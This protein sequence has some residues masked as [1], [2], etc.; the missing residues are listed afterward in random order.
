[1]TI[2][3]NKKRTL[4]S[5]KRAVI[6]YLFGEARAFMIT[7]TNFPARVTLPFYR[8]HLQHSNV[9]HF[10]DE[11]SMNGLKYVSFALHFITLTFL[12]QHATIRNYAAIRL[13]YATADVIYNLNICA[14]CAYEIEKKF[15]D[16]EDNVFLTHILHPMK[17]FFEILLHTCDWFSVG[18]KKCFA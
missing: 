3:A 14:V 13:K 18:M 7:F 4:C 16:V 15:M 2:S 6:S 1:M 10:L 17:C 11:L 8:F 12:C 5:G 9:L